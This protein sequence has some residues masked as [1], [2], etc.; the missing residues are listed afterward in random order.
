MVPGLGQKPGYDKSG[1][2]FGGTGR[3][4]DSGNACLMEHIQKKKRSLWCTF[5]YVS[6]GVLFP[7]LA[8]ECTTDP[9]WVCISVGLSDTSVWISVP[10][11]QSKV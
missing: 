6:T 9:I 5:S 3:A 10:R 2:P 4:S 1:I 7:V 11:D 8:S